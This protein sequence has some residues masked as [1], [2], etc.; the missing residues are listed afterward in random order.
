MKRVARTFGFLAVFLFLAVWPV[1]AQER[2]TPPA[3]TPIGY[4]FHWLNFAIV[5]CAIAYAA[6]KWG[7]PYF[8]GQA[9]EIAQKI[10]EGTRAREAAERQKKEI[11][12]K[13]AG[14]DGEIQRIKEE[15]KRDQQAEAKRLHD[16]ARSEAEKIEHAAQMEI[17]AAGRAANQELKARAARLAIERA[18]AMLQK[19]ITPQAEAGLFRTFVAEMERSIN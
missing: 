7:G 4:I 14:L 18:E 2:E 17:E 13:L 6:K 19:E 11:E 5:F 12:Q 1:R 15:G 9:E 10:A 8:H 3:E 16:L